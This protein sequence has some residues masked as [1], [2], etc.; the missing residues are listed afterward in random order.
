[1]AWIVSLVGKTRVGTIDGF[2]EQAMSTG[3]IITVLANIPWGQV[4]DNAPKVADG[5]ARLWGAVTGSRKPPAPEPG[6]QPLSETERLTA[7]VA[8]LESATL[9]L[10]EQMRAS[11]ELIKALADQNTQLVQRVEIHRVRLMR[12]SVAASVG[13]LLLAAVVVY[14]LLRS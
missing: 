7:Q 2:A 1:M 9:A 6:A 11:S 12:V 13:G 4:I 14:L 10:Q 5:A 8:A 3:A